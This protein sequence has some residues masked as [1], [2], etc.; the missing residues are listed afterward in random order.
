MSTAPST[1]QAEAEDSSLFG[2]ATR[3]STLWTAWDRIRANQGA[4]GGDGMTVARFDADARNRIS[5]LS[6]ALRT[7]RYRPG[8]SR[9]VFIPKHSGGVRPVDIPSV[10]DRVAQGGVALVLMRVLD[11]EMEDASFAYRPG[12]SVAQAVARVAKY[13]R[14]G[15]RY[16]VDGDIVRYFENVPHERLIARLEQCVNDLRL[17]DLVA[18]WLEQ[19]SHNERGLPQG[20][21][22]SPVLANLF[23]DDVDEA[24]EGR[25]VRLVRFADDFVLLCKTET[26]AK[27][28]LA[29]ITGLLGEHGLEIHPDKTRI[30]P[31]DQGFRFLG[32][33]FV[34]SMIWREV[35]REE[36]PSE[37]AVEAA[38][39]AIAAL[40]AE[41][42][43]KTDSDDAADLDDVPRGR[44][45]PR[46]RILYVVEPRRTL[47]ATNDCFVVRDD[48]IELIRVPYRR[49]DRIEVGPGAIIDQSA[50]D[51]A[52][53]GDTEIVRVDGHG[54]MLGVWRGR[55]DA[56]AERHLAQA[57]AILN[58][59]RRAAIARAIVKGRI[60]N[61]RGYLRRLDRT[62]KDPELDVAAVRLGR[63]LRKVDAEDLGVEEVMGHEG[64][65]AAIYWPA[66]A[67]AL[68]PV[69]S[70]GGKRARRT[71]ED[72]VNILFDV[73]S[74]LLARD[75]GVAAARHGL[76]LGFGA[77]HT[78]SGDRA[79]LVY[80]LME[81]FRAPVA[82]A[83]VLALIARKAVTPDMFAREEQRW[84]MTRDAWGPVIRGYEAWV[85]R[86]IKEPQSG[87]RMLW[88]ALFEVQALAYA[89]AC[90]KAAPYMP[91]EMDY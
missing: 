38:E 48:E 62:R 80:D 28:A 23:L 27:G 76:H 66:L 91:Y 46:Q 55:N 22:I 16:V 31:F 74:S 57:A 9:R 58:P 18:L 37:D 88:R 85:A 5:R 8:S 73:T 90:E 11:P 40:E 41:D 60:A 10:V 53:A 24:I 54:E 83:L 75:I 56:R 84:R 2:E 44:W 20:S 14:E 13:R 1:D 12:R 21:P 87:E 36:I 64:E 86:P 59:A 70:F 49:V 61:Q 78:T 50:L 33:V 89:R 65:A 17:V 26:I 19:H 69:W 3:F 43:E 47:V 15:F 77:L 67:R 25:G 71:R 79:S 39:R 4:A 52:V 35:L 42:A 30:V 51:L 7:G 34:R 68:D 6:H 29:R 81:E 63:I 72:P 45:S 82:E 32:H